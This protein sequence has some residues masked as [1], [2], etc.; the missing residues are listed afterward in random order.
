MIVSQLFIICFS[1]TSSLNDHQI[2]N[3][4]KFDFV[5]AQLD[6][7]SQR[8]YSRKGLL[9]TQA[10]DMQKAGAESCHAAVIVTLLGRSLVNARKVL[11][12]FVR[13][14]KGSLQWKPAPQERRRGRLLLW[15]RGT[16]FE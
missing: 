2:I 14:M 4:V 11:F 10:K 3:N 9:P 1:S 13:Q 15:D 8:E 16:V 5:N 6:Y 7:R 12:G